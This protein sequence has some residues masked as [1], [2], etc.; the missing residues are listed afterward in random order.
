M[1]KSRIYRNIIMKRLLLLLIVSLYLQRFYIDLG[2]ALKPFM[3]V[4]FLLGVFFFITK[5]KLNLKTF[6]Y[7]V[8]FLLFWIFSIIRGYFSV[9]KIEYFRM[10][11]GFII[12]L[13]LYIFSSNIVKF[14]KKEDI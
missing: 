13:I 9:Y 10:F 11:L 7:E 6:N 12:V 5:L 1:L 3:L 4:L 2:F 8:F 14:V